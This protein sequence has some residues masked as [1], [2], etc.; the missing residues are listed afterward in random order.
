MHT[1]EFLAK[2]RGV[3]VQRLGEIVEANSSR[4]F[5]W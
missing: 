2:V 3:S 4:L 1:A 5:G